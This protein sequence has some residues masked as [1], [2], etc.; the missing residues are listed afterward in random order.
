MFL[1]LKLNYH[2][3]K[4]IN[5]KTKA[6]KIKIKGELIDLK[7]PKIMGILNLTDD[8]FYDGGKHN[9]IDLALRQTEKMLNEGAFFI[10]IGAASSKPGSLLISSKEEIDKLIPFLKKLIQTFPNTHFSIDTYNSDVAKESLALGASM[11]N[12]IS[13]GKID[14][15]MFETVA[16]YKV[17]YIMMHMQGTPEHMQQNPHYIHITKEIKLKLAK[18]LKIAFKAGIHDVIIDPGFGFGKTV[19]QNFQ[20]LRELKALLDLRCPIMIG[21]SRKSMVYRTLQGSPE[22]AL[23]GTTALHAWGLERGVSILRVHDVKEAKECIDLF[24]ALQ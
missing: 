20:L 8:S 9:S 6:L 4:V 23:N 11:I 21:V 19:T 17:P 3:K 13:G 24:S 10:D 7:Q 22:T 1:N 14:P 2:L 18:R 12:D 15:K 5:N 16:E